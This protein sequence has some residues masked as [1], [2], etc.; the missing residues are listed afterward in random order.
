MQGRTG[1]AARILGCGVRLDEGVQPLF[2]PL[3]SSTTLSPVRAI[4][5]RGCMLH[6]ESRHSI[7][8]T[9]ALLCRGRPERSLHMPTTVI[10]VSQAIRHMRVTGAVIY[11]DTDTYQ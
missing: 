4:G 9:P 11:T 8:D 1:N 7:W 6:K 3:S 5:S 2:L 10:Y